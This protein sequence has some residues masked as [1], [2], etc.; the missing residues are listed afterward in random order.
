M[1]KIYRSIISYVLVYDTSYSK[2]PF[3][4]AGSRFDNLVT[5][6]R[7]RSDRTFY[8]KY[9]ENDELKKGHPTWYGERFSLKE[10]QSWHEPDEVA[11]TTYL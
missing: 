2:R 9:Q 4:A 7:V 1:I 10:P 6:A 3:L 11:E 8:Q 5:I